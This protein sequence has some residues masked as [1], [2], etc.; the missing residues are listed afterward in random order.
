MFHF[1][2]RYPD[3]G[4]FIVLSLSSFVCLFTVCSQ[5]RLMEGDISYSVFFLNG[6]MSS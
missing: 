5:R 6:S 3:V 4:N 1:E 2:L